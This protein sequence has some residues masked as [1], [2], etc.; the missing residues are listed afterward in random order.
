MTTRL[1]F[2]IGFGI[3]T[4]FLGV[5]YFLQYGMGLEPCPLCILERI[6]L[7]LTLIIFALAILHNP[8]KLGT[9]LYLMLSNISILMGL[10]VAIRHVY[11]QQL[12]LDKIPECGPGFDYLI[13]NFPL[14]EVLMLLFQGSGQC[15]RVG[16]RVLGLSLA[17]WTAVA[18]TSLFIWNLSPLLIK[19]KAKK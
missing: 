17:Q 4:A 5:A 6:T 3:C 11:L 10:G 12:P 18:F 9:R 16:A 13:K 7:F 2:L 14:S 15:A 1:F 19:L 8:K